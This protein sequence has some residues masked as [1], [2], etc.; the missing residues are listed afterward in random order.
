M[1]KENECHLIL[2]EQAMSI[3]MLHIL[4]IVMFKIFIKQRVN[5]M[6]YTTNYITPKKS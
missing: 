1:L 3:M 4:I 6:N 2:N 5:T